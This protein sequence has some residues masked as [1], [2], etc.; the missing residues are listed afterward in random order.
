MLRKYRVVFEG[1]VK[2]NPDIEPDQRE[3]EM[4]EAVKNSFR[5]D[6]QWGVFMTNSIVELV[7]KPE[8]ST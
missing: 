7:P 1:T 6:L 5:P 8:K 4:H 3:L 2:P